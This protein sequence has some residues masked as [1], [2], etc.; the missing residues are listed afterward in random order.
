[1]DMLYTNRINASRRSKIHLQLAEH[2]FDSIA[3]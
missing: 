1:M 2:H 3:L